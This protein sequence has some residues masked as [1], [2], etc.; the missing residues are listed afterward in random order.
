MAQ[1]REEARSHLPA[2]NGLRVIEC[3]GFRQIGDV[4]AR[5]VE[6]AKRAKWRKF[7]E[8]VRAHNQA[9]SS[10]SEAKTSESARCDA[11]GKGSFGQKR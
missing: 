2:R 6:R 5:I 4:A 8:D 11:K 1:T 9:A 3:G 10:G 7:I